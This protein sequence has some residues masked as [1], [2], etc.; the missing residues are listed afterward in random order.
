MRGYQSRRRLFVEPLESRRLLAAM[1]ADLDASGVLTLAGTGKSDRIEIGGDSTQLTVS[2]NKQ[3]FQFNTA[4]VTGINIDGGG[5]NDWIWVDDNVLVDAVLSGS[6]GNDRIHGGG[7]NDTISGGKGNDRLSGGAGN[8]TISG[9]A[10]NDWVWGDDG[11]DVVHGDAGNDHV[12]GGAG[13]DQ[14]FGDAGQ[15]SV[16]GDDGDDVVDGG[17]GHDRL[18]GGAGNDQLFGEAGKDLLWGDDG[19]DLLV[20]GGDNDHLWG[21]A[22]NDV[23]KGEAGS[24]HLDG[25]AGDNLLDGDAGRNQLTNGSVV[26]LDQNLTAEM[27]NASG[28]VALATFQYAIENGLVVQKLTIAVDHVPTDGV[29]PVDLPV[30][31]D[32][33]AVGSIAVDPATGHGS[34]TFTTS[35][36]PASDELPFPAGL[37][38]H[39]GSLITIGSDLSGTFVAEFA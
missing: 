24:D 37:A 33:L 28:A 30:T 9:G 15:D 4:D 7:G 31:I 26:D 22:G 25:G 14:V 36:T 35:A 18:H 39:D 11:D 17:A 21:G 8:D 3:S 1:H 32:A 6:A 10:G 2:F 29:T 20:G 23:L 16:N 19:D 13:N 27:T 12:F 5:G 34:L 38:L